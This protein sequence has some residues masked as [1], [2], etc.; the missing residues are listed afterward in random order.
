MELSVK[1][2]PVIFS[3]QNPRQEKGLGILMEKRY[4][5]LKNTRGRE[6]LET[7]N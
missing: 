1:G 2:Q 3:L 6:E 4:E 5:D 7:G